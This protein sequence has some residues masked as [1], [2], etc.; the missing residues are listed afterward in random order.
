[1]RLWPLRVTRARLRSGWAL[2]AVVLVVAV[3]ACTTVASVVLVEHATEAGAVR[4]AL[5]SLSTEQTDLDVSMTL[6]K[7]SV[8]K[9]RTAADRAISELLAGSA[10]ARGSGFAVSDLDSAPA[11]GTLP[12]LAYFGEWDAVK[13]H[14]TLTAGRWAASVK[15]VTGT[16]PVT[17]PAAAAKGL[18]LRVG[19]RFD[20]AVGLGDRTA[21]V[22][23]LYKAIAPKGD[24]W[25]SDLLKG[26]GYR[27]G[28]PKPGT[29]A[30]VPTDAFGPLILPAG[31][32]DAAGIPVQ[33]ISITYSPNFSATTPAELAPLIDRLAIAENTVPTAMGDVAD[34]VYFSSNAE[35]PLGQIAANLIVT[36]STLVVVSLLLLVLAIATLVQAARLLNDSRDFE[37]QL[38]RARGAS[39]GQILALAGMEAALIVVVTALLSPLLGGVVYSVLARQPA[40][41][42]ARMPAAAGLP[43]SVW[44]VSLAISL[45]FGLVLLA[46]L[47]ARPATFVDED[48]ARFRQHRGTGIMRTGADLGV[49]VIAGLV[50][51]RLV[52]YR[53]PVTATSTLSVDPILAAG[54]AIVLL[55]CALLCVRL[56]PVVSRGADSIGTR[57]KGAIFA[58]AAWE[59]SRR[60]RRATAAVLVLVIAIAIGTFGQTFLSTW[61]QSQID[62]AVLAVGPPVRVSA[63]PATVGEQAESLATGARGR[64]QPVIRRTATVAGPDATQSDANSTDGSAAV[65]L[66]LTAKA[67]EF[68]DRGRLADEGG[69]QVRADIST[70]NTATTRIA[71]PASATGVSLTARAGAATTPFAGVSLGVRAIVQDGNGLLSTLDLGEIPADGNAHSMSG[72][73][74]PLTAKVGP[75]EPLSIVGFQTYFV[76]TNPAVYSPGELQ[77]IT[78]ISVKDIATLSGAV[79][80]DSDPSLLTFSPGASWHGVN[81]DN[82]GAP[83]LTSRIPKGWQLSLGVIV[84]GDLT[85][86]SAAYALVGWRPVSTIPAV[87]TSSLATDVVAKPGTDLTLAFSSALVPIRLVATSPLIPGSTDTSQLT[88][89]TASGADASQTGTVV[90]DQSA[91]ERAL[92]QQGVAGAMADEWWV[93]VA[94]SSAAA[95]VDAHPATG[96][97]LPTRSGAVLAQA[98]QNDPLRVAIPT[99]LWLAIIAAVLLAAVGFAVHSTSSIRSRR[100]EFAEL[101]A[102]GLSRR[103]LIGVIA[104]ESL[105]L[106]ALGAVLG[107]AVGLAV[108]WLV[109]PI[110]AVSPD[111]S[112]PVPAVQLTI[113]WPGIALLALE[114]IALLA[115]VVAIAARIQ[116]GT[117]P[118]AVLRE[119]GE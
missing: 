117:E 97:T 66:G 102:V 6:P 101:R 110:V 65:V 99:A 19:S 20:V 87:M 36:R 32:L 98:M 11:L 82:R 3:L 85:A 28:F 44:L 29:D 63:D 15:S 16:I 41:M 53:S 45:V 77:S 5:T 43:A 39:R 89:R 91:L 55:A 7:V 18:G 35:T 105:L 12:A 47:V 9:A 72:W 79:G 62:Q 13:S 10:T 59:V 31:G 49:V 103:S 95:Y 100:L 83:P 1:M 69:S 75:A 104:V 21:R 4:T 61:R 111:G 107:I 92:A 74:P 22:V 96:G 34:Q 84:P 76:A 50:F 8:H 78:R 73:M 52:I 67:R 25:S 112:P 93:D 33:T 40:M 24:Y 38:M 70:P 90:V 81:A 80:D 119:V 60:S 57:A 26:A 116:R 51:W 42:Q 106:C 114:A 56:I 64:P 23:G 17:L 58:L 30:Y 54:P 88:P 14:A 68:V 27:A 86:Q 71:L 37:R 94:D 108:S 113:P 118:S 48:K 109:G 2:L 46:P 115:A